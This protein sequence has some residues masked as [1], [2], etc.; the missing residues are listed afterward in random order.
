M[1]FTNKHQSNVAYC[2]TG[3]SNPLRWAV[4]HRSDKGFAYQSGLFKCT[5]YLNDLVSKYEGHD[6]CVYGFDTKP[7]TLNEEGVYLHLTNIINTDVFADNIASLNEWFAKSGF[8]PIQFED[9]DSVLK[10]AV[11]LIPRRY[12]KSTYSISFA[13]YFIRVANVATVVSDWSIHPTK[14]LDNPFGQYYNAAMKQGIKP[15]NDNWY[16][17]MKNYTTYPPTNFMYVHDAGVKQ[18]LNCL[19]LEGAL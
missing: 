4:L 14:P 18:W 7:M 10:S 11:V 5:D 2:E 13:S 19:S 6:S 9:L 8:P 3:Q 15:P 17:Y 12:F 1:K 16:Y